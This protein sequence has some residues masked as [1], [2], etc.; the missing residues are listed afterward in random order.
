[1]PVVVNTTTQPSREIA[2]ADPGPTVPLPSTLTGLVSTGSLLL[3]HRT[4]TKSLRP[5]AWAPTAMSVADDANATRQ[6][7]ASSDGRSEAPL[8]WTPLVVSE[9]NSLAPVSR[10]STMTSPALFVSGVTR[11]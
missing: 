9:A 8:G 1:M 6:P 5:G 3:A 2:G 4:R 11:F 7:L 10:F